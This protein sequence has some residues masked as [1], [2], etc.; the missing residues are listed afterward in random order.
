MRM[1]A[2]RIYRPKTEAKEN[3]TIKIVAVI[4]F[5]VIIFALLASIYA[6]HFSKTSRCLKP[7][8]EESVLAIAANGGYNVAP[9]NSVTYNTYTVPIYMDKGVEAMPSIESIETSMLEY[10]ES[11]SHCDDNIRVRIEDGKV[12]F[13]KLFRHSSVN[14]DFLDIYSK[15]KAL[16]DSQKNANAISLAELARMAKQGDYVLH[17]NANNNTILYFMTFSKEKVKETP[18]V[19]CFGIRR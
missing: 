15:A 18:L 7:V 16:F 10:A 5:I 17:I 9:S 8:A 4:A 14:V 19:Y 1:A 13:G 2:K 6:S 3:E 11:K 12:R